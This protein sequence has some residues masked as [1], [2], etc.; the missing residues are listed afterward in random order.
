MGERGVHDKKKKTE[1]AKQKEIEESVGGGAEK[2]DKVK[3]IR[4]FILCFVIKKKKKKALIRSWLRYCLLL[5]GY[6]C[7]SAS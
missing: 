6:C 5:C 4:V 7:L 1:K 2:L 3:G